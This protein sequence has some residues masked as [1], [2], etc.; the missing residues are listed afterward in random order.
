MGC[1]NIMA[2]PVCV[3]DGGRGFFKA[4][5]ICLKGKTK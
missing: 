2:A 3:L 4:Y 1:K 5:Q